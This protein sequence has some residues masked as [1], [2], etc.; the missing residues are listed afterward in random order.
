M[1]QPG[2]AVVP[3]GAT[4]FCV[5]IEALTGRIAGLDFSGLNTYRC[6]HGSGAWT[7]AMAAMCMVLVSLYVA[8]SMK[9]ITA[10]LLTSCTAITL[11]GK[12]PNKTIKCTACASCARRVPAGARECCRPVQ[13]LQPT[14]QWARRWEAGARAAHLADMPHRVLTRPTRVFEYDFEGAQKARGRENI[15]RLEVRGA[16]GARPSQARQA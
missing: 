13:Q 3:A 10:P 2:A 7:P 8:Q 15:L 16:A 14:S 4:L 12:L 11:T 5:G 6:V 1:L 9:C